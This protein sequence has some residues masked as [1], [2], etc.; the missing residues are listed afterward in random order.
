MYFGPTL[1]GILICMIFIII[2]VL[3]VVI[4]L[5]KQNEEMGEWATYPNRNIYPDEHHTPY[6]GF[7]AHVTTPLKSK[8]CPNCGELITHQMKF[9]L[10]QGF[11]TF[12]EN[13]GYLI[14]P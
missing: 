11:K 2:I 8:F 6:M 5:V 1:S 13:C 7:P 3:I 4:H 9:R 14:L 12:C 10:E